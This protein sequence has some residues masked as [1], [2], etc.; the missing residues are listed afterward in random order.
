MAR[1]SI[2]SLSN[3]LKGKIWLSTVA[4]AFFVCTFGTLSYI[5]VSFLVKDPFYAIFIPFLLLAITI[6]AFGLWLS[7]EI[8]GPVEKVLLLARSLER[9]ISTSLPKTS[10]AIETDE[11][12][13]TIHRISGQVQRLVASLDNIAQENLDAASL[14]NSSS[15]RISQSFQKLLAK[16]SE[17]IHAKQDLDK[18]QTAVRQLSEESSSIKNGRLNV[19]VSDNTNSTAE[20]AQ[21]INYLLEQ[22]SELTAQVKSS[23]SK[24]QN[25]AFDV[26]KSLREVIQRDEFRLQE[27]NEATLTLKKVPQ[28][29]H[30]ISDE[31]S[32]SALSVSQ[33]IEKTRHGIKNARVNFD[34][35]TQLRRQVQ[36]SAKRMQKL[37]ECSQEIET[38]A[39]TVGDLAQRTNLV[40]LNASVQVAELG[41]HGR[42][43]LVISEE[44]ERLAARADKT[45]K[46]INAL[47]KA[48]QSEIEKVETSLELIVGEAANFSK[49]T[50]ETGNLNTDMERYLLSYLSLQQKLAEYTAAQ[51]AGTE[52]AFQTLSTAVEEIPIRTRNLKNSVQTVGGIAYSLENLQ[53]TANHF[54]FVA[55]TLKAKNQAADTLETIPNQPEN[56]EGETFI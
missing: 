36:E 31:I 20:I 49:F 27:I 22:L 39:K 1:K 54:N 15:D 41:E 52:Q 48:I 10:G 35:M 55:P 12:L 8:V 51:T 14:Q 24:S 17:S 28:V 23:S 53:A 45:N 47:N 19:T 13:E 46:Q 4:L 29:V 44:I 5:V 3:S 50:I 30:R 38:A 21:T 33:S 42:K 18:L 2:D 11:L 37:N 56:I 26:E 7:S 40:A 9:G 6:V 34:A 25:A 43:F 32:Q 16:V